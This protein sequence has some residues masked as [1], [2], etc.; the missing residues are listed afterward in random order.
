MAEHFFFQWLIWLPQSCTY[1]SFTAVGTLNDF[2][3]IEDHFS[4]TRQLT[5]GLFTPEQRQPCIQ[6][7]YE[8]AGQGPVNE[9]RVEPTSQ[10]YGSLLKEKQIKADL[11]EIERQKVSNFIRNRKIA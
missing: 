4:A 6:Y 11:L 1:Y 2:R 5:S 7:A 8:R 9:I 10:V 3:K